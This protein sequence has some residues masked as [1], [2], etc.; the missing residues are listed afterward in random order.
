VAAINKLGEHVRV[1]PAIA[2][3]GL[4]VRSLGHLWGFHSPGNAP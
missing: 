3:N 4:Y 1:T 2:G